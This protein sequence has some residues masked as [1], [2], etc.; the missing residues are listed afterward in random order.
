MA[1]PPESSAR[2]QIGQGGQVWEKHRLTPKTRAQEANLEQ[3][4]QAGAF[5]WKT[6]A[7]IF[8]Y[9]L[10]FYFYF[11]FLNIFKYF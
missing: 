6:P 4:S 1:S 7:R 2:L 3:T 9:F 11:V 10:Y 8:K 5:S